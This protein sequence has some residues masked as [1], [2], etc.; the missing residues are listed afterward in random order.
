MTVIKALWQGASLAT[1]SVRC[2]FY[3]IL[4]TND[5]PGVMLSVDFEKAFDQVSHNFIYRVLDNFS[6]GPSIIRCIKLFYDH[7]SSSVLVISTKLN[8]PNGTLRFL[9][10]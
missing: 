8:G 6:F 9:D 2:M 4:E 7:A 10:E 3:V 5:N 1:T